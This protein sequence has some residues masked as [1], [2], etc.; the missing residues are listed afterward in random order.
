MSHLEHT[1]VA[2]GR[3]GSDPSSYKDMAWSSSFIAFEDNV[4]RGLSAIKA[5]KI[6]LQLLVSNA[7]FWG[8][9]QCTHA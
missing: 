5:P 8:C 2:G 9:M 3:Q 4:Q 1:R 6:T 7:V